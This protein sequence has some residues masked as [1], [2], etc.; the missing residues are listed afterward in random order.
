MD[1][2]R[3]AF[4]DIAIRRNSLG[5]ILRALQHPT[6]FCTLMA[7]TFVV[8]AIVWWLLPVA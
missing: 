5:L 2:G 4:H 6:T 8:I 3:D 7:I 1:N